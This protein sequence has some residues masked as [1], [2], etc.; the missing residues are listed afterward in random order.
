MNSVPQVK[1]KLLWLEFEC[2][3]VQPEGKWP[4]SLIEQQLPEFENWAIE[5][6]APLAATTGASMCLWRQF[7][8]EN[9][10]GVK[11]ALTAIT[12]LADT[13]DHHPDVRFS[14]N[15]ITV[16]WNTHSAGGLSNN[17]WACAAQL[18]EQLKH[19]G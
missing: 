11:L 5:F 3:P 6:E 16:S 18:D 2:S 12:R 14:Y 17:D 1:A 9:F 4:L 10:E 7:A 19:L 15:R 13:Q 8:F